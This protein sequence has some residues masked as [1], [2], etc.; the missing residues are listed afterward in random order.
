MEL[1]NIEKT[2]SPTKTLEELKTEIKVWMKVHPHEY[3]NF[4]AAMNGS[5]MG[6]RLLALMT[7][8]KIKTLEDD[9]EVESCMANPNFSSLLSMVEKSDV[10]KQ[11]FEE[12]SD[13]RNAILAW[14]LFARTY[15]SVVENLETMI[16]DSRF[17]GYRWMLTR[18]TK[19]II[20]RS[21][22]N[23]SRTK[24][25][26]EEYR[27]YRKAVT[28][29]CV[30][31]MSDYDS[32]M[33]ALCKA[34]DT[35]QTRNSLM[36]IL[37]D[38]ADLSHKM[39]EWLMIRHSGTDEAYLIIALKELGYD[40][41]SIQEFHEALVAQYPDVKFVGLRAVQKQLKQLETVV[42]MGKFA[43]KDKGNDRITINQIKQMLSD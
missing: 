29:G 22:Q 34:Y 1:D 15:E 32:S 4:V 31:D 33:I 25:D 18:F 36:E 16:A 42:G 14:L 8:G 41:D 2:D 40:I 21:M 30:V 20:S 19:F 5:N 24:E 3:A 38:K 7:K 27:K 12:E 35:T 11:L 39:G 37:H 10:P 6:L 13:R 17:S 28:S 23:G 26:R 9:V 43:L